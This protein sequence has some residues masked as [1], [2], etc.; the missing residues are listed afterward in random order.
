[1]SAALLQRGRKYIH[2]A[3][4]TFCVSTRALE[5]D[6]IDVMEKY[7]QGMGKELLCIGFVSSTVPQPHDTNDELGVIAFL[8]K[9]QKEYGDKSLIYIAFGTTFWPADPE[10]IYIVIDELIRSR[11]P[12]LFAH[13]SAKTAIPD[14][15]TE[16]IAKSG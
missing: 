12:F 10:K 3:D 8:D 2:E 13:G 6:S 1:M 5:R 16:K 14:E 4:G 7:L 9:M 15:V 11:T